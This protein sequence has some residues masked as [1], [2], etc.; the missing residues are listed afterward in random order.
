MVGHLP[1]LIILAVILLIFVSGTYLLIQVGAR[2]AA[3]EYVRA[4]AKEER[5]Q[6]QEQS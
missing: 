4:R 3:R 5:R 1:E 2:T 6:R